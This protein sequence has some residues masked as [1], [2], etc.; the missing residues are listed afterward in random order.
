M[1]IH[2]MERFGFQSLAALLK[3][4]TSDPNF[5]IPR[6]SAAGRAVA[7]RRHL[8]TEEDTGSVLSTEIERHIF[9]LQSRR[10]LALVR[11]HQ[12]LLFI[13]RLLAAGLQLPSP[14]Y[15]SKR[16]P[17]LLEAPRDIRQTV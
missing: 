5:R 10:Q 16:S 11:T 7:L 15:P 12:N 6:V 1:M 9:V 17:S 2:I 13:A 3:S 4:K 14:P 8:D